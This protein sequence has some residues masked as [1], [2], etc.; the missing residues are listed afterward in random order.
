[1]DHDLEFKVLDLLGKNLMSVT[2]V[3]NTLGIRKD[4]AAK[5]LD[6]LKQEGKLELFVVGKSNV[7]TVPRSSPGSLEKPVRSIGVVSGK[8]GVGKTVIS[9]NLAA[10]LMS[11]GK[12][13]I[14]IDA[15]IKMSGLGL[16]LGM[17]CFPVTLNDVLKSS[18]DILKAIYIHPSGLR[19]IPSSLSV[20]LADFSN[21][22]KT[23]VSPFFENSLLIVD[24]PP[25]LEASNMQVLRACSEVVLVT[26]P[27]VPAIANLIKTIDACQSAGS[28]PI[29]VIV[30]RYRRGDPG[31]V[32]FREIE[33]ACELPVL[34]TIPEDKAIRASI[35]R[36]NPVVFSNPYASSSIEFKKIAARILG[37]NYSPPNFFRRLLGGIRI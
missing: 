18:V 35:Y 7:Y 16:Q 26:L 28:K 14:A 25:G 8:G 27:E 30:N 37:F 13:V 10:A 11:F 31:Q 36:K 21:L 23:L 1:M 19:I 32:N 20:D 34:G 29:G 2:Q 17:Y 6:S 15:D 33:S 24:S 3:A 5:H 12:S 22:G 9:I 4:I